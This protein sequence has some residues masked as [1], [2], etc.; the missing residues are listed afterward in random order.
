M[1]L[2]MA[3]AFSVGAVD[4]DGSTYLTRGGDLTGIADGKAGT[5]SFWTRLSSTFGRHIMASGTGTSP[6]F[7][8]RYSGG[9]FGINCRDSGANFLVNID[10]AQ[11]YDTDSGWLHLIASWKVDTPGARHLYVNDADDLAVTTF[12]DGTIDYTEG[13]WTVGARGDL[14]L[15][16]LSCLAEVWFDT[17]YLDLSL[18]A[19]RR[20][21][22][23]SQGRPAFLGES[24]ERPTGSAP[25]VYLGGPAGTWHVNK[26]TGG[27]FTETGAL[28]PCA[29]SPSD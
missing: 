6:H 18:P 16:W 28:A 24:G 22:I 26:G 12:A 4:F 23:N 7:Q 5:I 27:G 2:L 25:L 21:F 15:E 8:V 14:Q 29:S 20:R 3:P 9:A 11:T 13:E 17:T 19:N 10:T 1:R